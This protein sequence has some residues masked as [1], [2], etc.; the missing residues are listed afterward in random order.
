[1]VAFTFQVARPS[2]SRWHGQS[3]RNPSLVVLDEPNSN[4][5]ADGDEAL[6]HCIKALRDAGTI[7]VVVTHR[8]SAMKNRQHGSGAQ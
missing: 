7:T 2:A 4:L 5:D 8:P 6:A 3:F 1:M